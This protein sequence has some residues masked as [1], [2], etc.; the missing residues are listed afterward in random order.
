MAAVQ[1]G[2]HLRLTAIAL[3]PL[4]YSPPKNELT[5]YVL[6]IHGRF[7]FFSL[8]YRQVQYLYDESS[9]EFLCVTVRLKI[10]SIR[11]IRK[12]LREMSS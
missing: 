7:F 9:N 11:L 10:N 2:A 5:F 4:R 12:I 1:P 6:F 3:G 8:F